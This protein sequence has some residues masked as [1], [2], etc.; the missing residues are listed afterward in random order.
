MPRPDSSLGADA[1]SSAVFVGSRAGRRERKAEEHGNKGLSVKQRKRWLRQDRRKNRR[2]SPSP[3]SINKRGEKGK[4]K[5]KRKKKKRTGF[6]GN[7]EA[8]HLQLRSRLRSENASKFLGDPPFFFSTA[9]K[10]LTSIWIILGIYATS[11]PAATA[12]YRSPPR[13]SRFRTQVRVTHAR[14]ARRA[15]HA[16]ACAHLP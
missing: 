6:I 12:D 13:F 4:K 16:H 5:T 15:H 1:I 8:V 10:Y 9:Q 7:Q 11:E 2:K 3:R 14:R